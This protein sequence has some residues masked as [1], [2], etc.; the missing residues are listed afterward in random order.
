MERKPFGPAFIRRVRGREPAVARVL[1]RAAPFGVVVAVVVAMEFDRYGFAT[2]VLAGVLAC[3]LYMG[4]VPAAATRVAHGVAKAIAWFLLPSGRSTPA[5]PDFSLEKSLLA[6][7][8]TDE[9]LGLLRR[10]LIAEP[11]NAALCVFAA[12]AY[13]GAGDHRRA[14]ALFRRA[15]QIPSLAAGQ[16]LY[17]TNRLIDLYLGP[18]DEPARA[19]EELRYLAERHPGSRE[20]RHAEQVIRSLA[21]AAPAD[22]P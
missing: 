2:G 21:D 5:A 19:A 8:R 1:L 18:L 12:D 15:R 14:E 17:A 20:A 11:E 22:R 7:G 16:D 6:R 9:A 4:V 13:A 10:R 3:A